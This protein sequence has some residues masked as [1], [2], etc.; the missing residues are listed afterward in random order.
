MR[1]VAETFAHRGQRIFRR[2]HYGDGILLRRAPY[3]A[4][5][6]QCGHAG[7]GQHFS[8]VLFV[9]KLLRHEHRPGRQQFDFHG[10]VARKLS[11]QRRRR[12]R[13]SIQR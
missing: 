7:G 4:L 3:G 9:E 12:K 8:G 13:V 10:A 11:G 6:G 1:A 2:S 5:S